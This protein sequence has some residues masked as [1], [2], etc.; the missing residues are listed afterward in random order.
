MQKEKQETSLGIFY[1]GLPEEVLK[2]LKE[3]GQKTGKT[4][5]QCLSDAV[6]D[7]KEK[8]K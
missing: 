5:V 3:I 8:N 2:D 1:V 7:L 6:H 4:V